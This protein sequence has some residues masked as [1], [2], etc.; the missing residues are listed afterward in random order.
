MSKELHIVIER[1]QQPYMKTL[2]GFAL[3]PLGSRLLL[4]KLK[5]V[6]R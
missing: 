4:L 3:E 5:L 2:V 6:S 1:I